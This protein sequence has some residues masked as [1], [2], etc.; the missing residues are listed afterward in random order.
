M[1][2]NIFYFHPYL[3]KWSSLTNIFQMGWNHQ[4]GLGII[5]IWPDQWH[6]PSNLELQGIYGQFIY[7]PGKSHHKIFGESFQCILIHRKDRKGVV[8]MLNITFFRPS[9]LQ[10]NLYWNFR[11]Q[12]FNAFSAGGFDPGS[13]ARSNKTSRQAVDLTNPLVPVWARRLEGAG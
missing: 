5:V 2:S 11:L 3:G 10:V 1:V 8:K 9:K 13:L 7:P 6:W 12:W 4:L